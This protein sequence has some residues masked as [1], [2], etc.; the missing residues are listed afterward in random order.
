MTLTLFI[1][2]NCARCQTSRYRLK[3]DD[4]CLFKLK[5]REKE[6]DRK[7]KMDLGEDRV[8]RSL[9]APPRP[10]TEGQEDRLSLKSKK[11]SSSSKSGKGVSIQVKFLDDS[12][13]GFRVQVRDYF[14]EFKFLFSCLVLPLT[15]IVQL[16]FFDNTVQ[17]I[18]KV[19]TRAS[20]WDTKPRRGRLL[21][22]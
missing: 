22:S 13:T 2:I 11:R 18:R 14:Y 19:V 9:S 5:L 6:E 20:L 8:G 12:V 17:G 21:W 3:Q 7:E 4:D 1:F 10:E 16:I 15:L